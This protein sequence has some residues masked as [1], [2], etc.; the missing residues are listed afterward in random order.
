METPD[1]I[2]YSPPCQLP[3]PRIA[4][5]WTLVMRNRF[6]V[7]ERFDDSWASCEL[8]WA[9]YKHGDVRTA[10]LAQR[11]TVK[12][13]YGISYDITTNKRVQN[14]A[15]KN[16]QVVWPW[17]RLHWPP[18]SVVRELRSRCAWPCW[19]FADGFQ[20]MMGKGDRMDWRTSN[21]VFVKIS[22]PPG[23]MYGV[24]LMW[25]RIGIVYELCFR[26]CALEFWELQKLQTTWNVG[27]D[28]GLFTDRKSVV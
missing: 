4:S 19:C 16:S 6:S 20:W 2:T 24:K 9:Y 18:C 11:K 3:S 22:E 26:F 23:S 25:S 21:R 8:S 13:E 17:R 5:A 1:G 7:S 14:E 15:L 28:G 12:L 10:V 27:I